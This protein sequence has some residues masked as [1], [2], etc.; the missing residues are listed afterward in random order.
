MSVEY[1]YDITDFPGNEVSLGTLSMEIVASSISVEL[2][3]MSLDNDA[4][5]IWF[6]SA[7]S[8]PEVTTLDN[9]V[10]NHDTYYEPEIHL[11]TGHSHNFTDLFDTPVTYSGVG[12]L[13]T[14]VKNTENGLEFTDTLSGINASYPID[15][16]NIATKEYV[17]S[18]SG[19]FGTDHYY[20]Q[21]FGPYETTA[22]T[23]TTT[24]TLNVPTVSSGVFRISTNYFWY[25]G[26]SKKDFSARLYLDNSIV[27]REQIQESASVSLVENHPATMTLYYTFASEGSHTIDFQISSGQVDKTAGVEQIMIEIW[28]IS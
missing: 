16:D 5:S 8:G 18:A 2:D 20:I 27:L 9:I 4:V 14:A 19:V 10:A 7:L 1:V 3:Y 28:R 26:A 6:L 23:Y 15:P 17:D 13:I 25:H 24:V 21:D 11:P 22:I 12:S